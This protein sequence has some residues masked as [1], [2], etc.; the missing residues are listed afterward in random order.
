MHWPWIARPVADAVSLQLRFA[1]AP[2][3]Q[4]VQHV[5]ALV[6]RG[7]ADLIAESAPDRLRKCDSPPCEE[8]FVDHSKSGQQRFC[9]RRCAT[10]L[11][12]AMVRRHKAS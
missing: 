6:T 5:E 11:N 10:R 2:Q 8:I 9:G 1:P 4:P 7:I 3:L 12:V